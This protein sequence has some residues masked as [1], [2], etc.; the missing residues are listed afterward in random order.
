[1][2]LP[3]GSLVY[4]GD[5]ADRK[6][7]VTLI[8]YDETTYEETAKASLEE[9]LILVNRTNITWLNLDGLHQVETLEK[10]GQCFSLHPLVLEDILNTDQR[11][12]LEDYGDY[13]YLVLKMLHYHEATRKIEVEHISLVLGPNYVISLHESGG[14][15]FSPLKE[16]LKNSKGRIRRE[17]ADYLAY[18]LLDLIVDQYFILLEKLGEDIEDLEEELVSNPTQ[19]TLHAMHQLKRDLLISR[20]SVWPLR[21]VLS[22]LERAES[23]L[24]KEST[25]V[26][27]RDVYDHVIQVID[28]I[29]T[30]R[31]MLSGMLDIYLSSISNRL[32]E[33]MKMLT[34]I[35]T[36]FIPLTFVAGVYG[37]NFKYMP[38]LEWYWGYF[39]ALG[40]M[41][42]IAAVML[43][44]FRRKGW[45]GRS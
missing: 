44:Y 20:K 3:P 30:F 11:P 40:I 33:I 39:A 21:E 27:L 31:E 23:P 35:A 13:L 28:T 10:L 18:A 8:N 36:I 37:M 2:G 41:G 12:K 32:N 16:R 42:T 9:C 6:V 15:F 43:A 25:G 24:I 29:E 5:K 45:F 1:M 38:E 26:Y 19:E 14:E 17:G 4:I 22:R 34:I 7:N